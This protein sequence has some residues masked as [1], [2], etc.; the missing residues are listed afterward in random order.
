[1]I[2]ATY[3]FFGVTFLSVRAFYPRLLPSEPS[4][5]SDVAALARLSRRTWGYLILSASLPMLAVVV[6][7]AIDGAQG[8][9]ILGILSAGSLLGF[10]LIFYLARTI[11]ADLVTLTWI[12]QPKIDADASDPGSFLV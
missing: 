8:R 7:V 10:G 12:V 1:M 11:Q 2:A 6:L 4:A 5:D 9:L 3:P